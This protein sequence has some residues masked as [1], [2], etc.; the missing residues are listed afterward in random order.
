LI[1]GHIADINVYEKPPGLPFEFASLL[2]PLSCVAQGI[3]ELMRTRVLS[4]TS[5]ILVLGPG[6]IGLM[7]VAALRLLGF[8]DLTLGGRSQH[9][10]SIG[11]SFGAR[12]LTW[13]QLESEIHNRFDAVIECIGIVGIWEKS[14][15]FV[16]RG[17]LLMLFGGCPAGTQVT[18]DTKRLHYDQITLLSPF[19]FGT[20]AVR[21]A[22]NWLQDK[23]MD[24]SALL[25]GT[26]LLSEVL[27]VFV[28]LKNGLGIKYVFSQ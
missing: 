11:A 6:A 19:H 17:G 7:F 13:E 25:S 21:T 4:E 8:R 28:D 3:K 5:R 20:E 9:R 26:R 14:I 24:L 18:F 10:L 2:E 15:E 27:L 22:R 23:S 16:R 12:A 1:P